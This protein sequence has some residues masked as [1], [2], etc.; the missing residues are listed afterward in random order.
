MKSLKAAA[1]AAGSLI[2]AGVASPAMAHSALPEVSYNLDGVVNTTAD[3]TRDA[4]GPL[5]TVSL[6][7]DSDKA[8]DSESK[9]SALHTVKDTTHTLDGR[10]PLLGGLPVQ[11]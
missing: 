3:H 1:V 9:G 6:E 2:V 5:G 10:T 11:G 8:L 4:K 7:V